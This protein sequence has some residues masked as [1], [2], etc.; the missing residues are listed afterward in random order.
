VCSS[1]LLRCT[2]EQL[3]NCRMAYAEYKLLSKLS[4]FAGSWATGYT[5]A[6][7]HTALSRCR[8]RPVSRPSHPTTL[9][10]LSPPTHL[11]DKRR[12]VVAA[13]QLLTV[14]HA[15]KLPGRLQPAGHA[16]GR[17]G[18]H[19]AKHGPGCRAVKPS[20]SRNCRSAKVQSEPCDAMHR[21]GSKQSNMSFSPL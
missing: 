2:T 9:L 5:K 4:N 10:L 12:Q 20:R 19:Q 1:D 15:P 21:Q 6:L 13:A 17:L 18:G 3:Q 16:A 7:P 14:L 11:H 8:H